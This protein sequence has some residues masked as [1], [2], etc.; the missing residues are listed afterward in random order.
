MFTNG[1]I[2]TV[3]SKQPWAEC[4]AVTGKKIVYVGTNGGSKA[5]MGPKTKVIDLHGGMLMPGFIDGHSHFVSGATGKRGVSL[6]GSKDKQELL[7]RIRDY[8]KANPQR[9]YFMGFGWEFIMFG[10]KWGTRQELD[11]ICDNKPIILFNEDTH[12]TWFNTKAMNMGG[13]NKNTPDPVPGNSLYPREA[14]GTPQGIGIE[15][16]SWL[17]MAAKT[18]VFSGRDMLE[19]ATEMLFPLVSKAGITAYNDMGIWAPDMP[20]GYV[21]LGLLIEKEKAG[22]LPFRVVGTF[23]NRNIKVTP[24]AGIKTLKE[25]STRYHS[26]L[27][28]VKGIK[29][30]ADGTYLSHSSVQIEPYFDKPE[31]SGTS[32]WNGEALAKWIE[33]AYK[34]DFDVNIHCEGDLST[35]RALDG[36]E[37]VTKKLG[38]LNRITTLHHIT[39]VHPTDIPRFSALGVMGNMTPAWFGDYKDQYTKD[40]LRILGKDRLDKEFEPVRSLIESGANI[41]FGSDCGAT[42][43]EELYPLYQIQ[44]GVTGFVPG[45]S[46]SYVVPEDLRPT[47]AQMIYGYTLAGARQ[48]RMEDKIGSIEVGKFADIVV[49]EQN[50]FK[51]SPTEIQNNKII[52]TMMNGK[53]VYKA[54]Q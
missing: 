8:V 3:N 16:E 30:W 46:P 9:S 17:P 20:N 29:L 35:R 10:D 15:P 49:L 1:S 52:M 27:V 50:L 48:M 53:V 21:G 51:Q 18:G 4:V 41:S 7:Q 38:K 34:A 33:A 5:W 12:N 36:V 23:A 54:N 31:T 22:Q 42:D 6:V 44:A 11:A 40:A 28:Q 32:D 2:Y 37:K 43:I 19:E 47:L 26:E 25:W 14:D 39:L 45:T 24:E 13:I